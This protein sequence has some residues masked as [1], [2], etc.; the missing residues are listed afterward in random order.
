MYCAD[1]TRLVLLPP[2]GDSAAVLMEVKD[3]E[4]F[5]D[6]LRREWGSRS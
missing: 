3:P 5:L 6:D 2:K 1:G 4:K